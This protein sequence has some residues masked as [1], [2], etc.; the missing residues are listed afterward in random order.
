MSNGLITSL[1]LYPIKYLIEFF[2]PYDSSLE[3]N[4]LLTSMSCILVTFLFLKKSLFLSL[5]VTFVLLILLIGEKKVKNFFIAI[6]GV[7]IVIYIFYCRLKIN[8]FKFLK[9]GSLIKV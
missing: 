4:I 3:T 6:L 5:K 9:S 1:S 2:A 8:I 7:H